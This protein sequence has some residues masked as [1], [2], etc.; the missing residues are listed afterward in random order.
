L[1]F[2]PVVIHPDLSVSTTSSISSEP[3]AGGENR[4]KSER[5]SACRKPVVLADGALLISV[6]SRADSA[7]MAARVI[8][9]ALVTVL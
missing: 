6:N 1:V 5:R 9:K 8:H 2:G 7:P 4:R 3:I